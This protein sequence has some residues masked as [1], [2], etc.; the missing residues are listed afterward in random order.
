MKYFIELIVLVIIGVATRFLGSSRREEKKADPNKTLMR[1]PPNLR[2]SLYVLGIMFMIIF[3][4]GGVAAAQDGASKD[5]PWLPFLML[6]GVLASGLF[7]LGGYSMYARHVFFDDEE[8]LVGRPFRGLLRVGWKEI[9]RIETKRGQ[10]ILYGADGKRLV[11]ASAN[12]ENF[13]I[14]ENTVKR[15]CSAKQAPKQRTEWKNG[16][17][18][19]K[20]RAGAIALLILVIMLLA[21]F[22][23]VMM[24]SGYT[25]LQML[26]S[27]ETFIFSMMFIAAIPLLFYSIWLF[28]E[29]IR[30]TKDD[31]TF[32]KLFSKK[33]FSWD[34]LQKIRREQ[35]GK[36]VRKL[37]LTW[38]G[39]EYA[40]SPARYAKYYEEFEDF[41]IDIALTRDIPAQNL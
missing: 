30:Y 16:A 35:N 6:L 2:Y 4:Y 39:K 38:D 23:L 32:S 37:Y 19:M 12:L 8:L 34:R 3:C 41:V 22:A 31:I 17:R 13:D 28:A 9:S 29:K 33:T 5:A 40:V 20:R 10:I 1:Q 26:T 15:V 21:L 27:G 11:R 18:V 7:F 14:F 25:F 36:A 24:A